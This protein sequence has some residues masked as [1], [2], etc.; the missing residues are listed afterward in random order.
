MEDKDKRMKDL[1]NKMD[2][3]NEVY[4]D[5]DKEI[6]DE[7]VLKNYKDRFKKNMLHRENTYMASG[8][9][10][11]RGVGETVNSA[12]DQDT[13]FTRKTGYQDNAAMPY[14]DPNLSPKEA[15]EIAIKR[16]LES[17]A[18]INNISFYDEVNWNLQRMG[19]NSKL[20][21]DIKNA[22]TDMLKY[23]EIK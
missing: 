7:N 2:Q 17:G 14:S 1:I 6:L 11:V 4:K 22:I 23:G 20:P 9:Y 16:S 18:P 3:K 8:S 13:D 15:F 5:E 21:L 10:P 19:Q 12:F